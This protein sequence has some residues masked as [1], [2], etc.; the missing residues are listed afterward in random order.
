MTERAPDSGPPTGGAG[1]AAESKPILEQILEHM[2]ADADLRRRF[3]EPSW[4]KVEDW[5]ADPKDETPLREAVFAEAAPENEAA[6]APN[7]E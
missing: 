7:H 5:L 6:D 4:Q 3:D 1:V 2:R